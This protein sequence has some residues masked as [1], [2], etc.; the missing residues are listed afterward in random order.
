MRKTGKN[1]SSLLIFDWGKKKTLFA[2]FA[3]G[4]YLLAGEKKCVLR[5][6]AAAAAQASP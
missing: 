2:V 4:R 1:F 3:D 5:R 6:F